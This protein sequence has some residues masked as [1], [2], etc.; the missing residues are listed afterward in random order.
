MSSLFGASA[1]LLVIGVDH[2]GRNPAAVADVVTLR[3][4]PGADLRRLRL[5]AARGTTAGGTGATAAAPSG[6][7]TRPAGGLD[8]GLKRVTQLRGVLGGQVDFICDAVQREL[9]ALVRLRTVE[10]VDES[11]HDLLCHCS[12]L[13]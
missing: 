7:S 2:V 9:D 3:L 5:A 1:S 11:D 4:R 13:L 10:V 8:V 12:S 6:A